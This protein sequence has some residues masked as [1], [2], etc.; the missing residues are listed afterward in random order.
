MPLSSDQRPE[1]LVRARAAGG[2]EALYG[3]RIWPCA[4]GRSGI[5]EKKGEGD[6][7]TPI[8]S[9]PLRQ[10]YYRPDRLAEPKTLLPV[11]AMRPEW[12]W[13][14]DPQDIGYNRLVELP[15]KARHE[16]LWRD[17]RLYDLLVVLGYNDMP[18]VAGRGSA[19]FLHV[20]RPGYEPTEGCVAF[21]LPDLQELLT[22]I[23]PESLCC[24]EGV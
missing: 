10:V 8:G 20:A 18:V 23:A 14:D 19:I 4:V 1:L 9:W 13:C 21:S 12:G 7:I 2:Y 5:A 17:D 15:Y 24:I 6:G 11:S 16:R 22:L 3:A